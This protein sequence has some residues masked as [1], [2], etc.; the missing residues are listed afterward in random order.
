MPMVALLIVVAIVP[1]VHGKDPGS[2]REGGWANPNLP[3]P[4]AHTAHTR[5]PNTQPPA[6][7]L[8]LCARVGY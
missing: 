1:A 6:R 2:G 5:T 7:A 3:T 4:S 8:T